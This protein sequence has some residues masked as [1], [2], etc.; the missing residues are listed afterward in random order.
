MTKLLKVYR[1]S[2]T[3]ALASDCIPLSTVSQSG[4]WSGSAHA[5]LPSASDTHD[6]A[7]LYHAVLDKFSL[8]KG[9]G[10]FSDL[11]YYNKACLHSS[12]TLWYGFY[13]QS[14]VTPA[15]FSNFLPSGAS[16]SCPDVCTCL[17]VSFH[18]AVLN[19]ILSLQPHRL[20]TQD[21]QVCPLHR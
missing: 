8:G 6:V 18:S 3:S 16:V 2:R 4:A 9:S 10:C 5:R 19:Y 11:R 12:F 7:N 20:L 17:G 1:L 15:I 13:E 14:A 21:I